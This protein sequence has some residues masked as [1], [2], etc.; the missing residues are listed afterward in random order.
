MRSLFID[1][2][3]FFMNLAIIEN[4]KMLFSF[5]KEVK[6]DMASSIVS[7]IDIAFQKVPFTIKDLDKIFVVCGPGSFTGIRVGVTAAK[8]IAWSINIPVVPLSSL[9]LMATTS[10]VEEYSIPMIDARRG[11]VYAGVYDKQLNN[12]VADGLYNCEDFI[13]NLKYSYKIVSYD[14]IKNSVKPE[15][16]ILKI[17]SKHIEDSGV[18]ANELKPNYLKL[19]EA[20]EKR[21][22][23]K[24]NN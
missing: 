2:S 9:E 15:L 3:S 21:N 24:N 5:S 16:N 1:T 18:L 22:N 13:H 4:N 12:I 11:N 6:N 8:I 17:V 20:E 19:T 23:D 10:V 14:D 7:E